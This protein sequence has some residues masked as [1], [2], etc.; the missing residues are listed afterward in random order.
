[1]RT[2]I[3]LPYTFRFA[4]SGECLYERDVDVY[5]EMS[6]SSILI[7]DIVVSNHYL[8]KTGAIY[9]ML[10]EAIEGDKAWCENARDKIWEEYDASR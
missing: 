9:K 8:R 3:K 1:M 4:P 2:Q 10:A 7:Q 6:E 5:V